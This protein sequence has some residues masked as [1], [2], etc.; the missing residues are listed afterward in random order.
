MSLQ[1]VSYIIDEKVK[2]KLSYSRDPINIDKANP[3]IR[4]YPNN[5]CTALS[6]MRHI[7][8]TPQHAITC[9]ATRQIANHSHPSLLKILIDLSPSTQI[10]MLFYTSTEIKHLQYIRTDLHRHF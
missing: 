10:L 3:T 4:C 7:V 1:L 5:I 2:K 6:S 9:V 8:L